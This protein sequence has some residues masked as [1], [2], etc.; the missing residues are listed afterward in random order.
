MTVRVRRALIWLD[1]IELLPRPAVG[2]VEQNSSKLKSL[3]YRETH[4]HSGLFPLAFEVLPHPRGSHEHQSLYWFSIT[5]RCPNRHLIT[6]PCLCLLNRQRVL[7]RRRNIGK[8]EG[9]ASA[10]RHLF[11]IGQLD[12]G[13]AEQTRHQD[14]T[15]QPLPC[16]GEGCKRNCP[17]RKTP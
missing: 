16:K 11:T 13:R 1:R 8:M 4:T 9:E 17:V 15:L 14:W 6:W 5:R 12:P 10:S 2:C 3:H 7:Q